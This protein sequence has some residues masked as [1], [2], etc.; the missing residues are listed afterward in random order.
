MRQK[1]FGSASSAEKVTLYTLSIFDA[2]GS[3]LLPVGGLFFVELA[4]IQGLLKS[5]YQP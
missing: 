2:S 5:R 1:G 3:Y 4:G